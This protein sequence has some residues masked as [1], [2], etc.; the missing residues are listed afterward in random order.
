[1]KILLLNDY[2]TGIAGAELI[3][4]GL[5][6]E[7]RRRGHEAWLLSSSARPTPTPM[8]AD[9]QCLGTT[10]RWRTL[11]QCGNLSAAR[12]LRRVL[13]EFRPDVVHVNLYLTQLSPLILREIRHVPAV[14]YAQWYRAICPVGTKLLPDGRGCRYPVG[15]A[16]L[17]EGCLK[18]IDWPPLIAQMGLDR[19]WGGAF[20]R[21]VAISR[22]VADKLDAWGGPHLR[23]AQ[24]V[25]PGTTVV[26]PRPAGRMATAPTAMAAS[27]LSPEKGIDVLLRAFA[28]IHRDLPDAR[29]VIAGD[30]PQRAALEALSGNLGLGS[31]VEWTGHLPHEQTIERVREAWVVCVPSRWDEPFGLIAA[32]TQMNGVAVVASSCGGL[33]EIIRDGQTGLLVPPGDATLLAERLAR[34]LRNR[35]EAAA[36]GAAGHAAAAIRFGL[37]GF[38]SRFEEVYDSIVR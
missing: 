30:G 5:R 11:L 26:P 4:I 10:S 22:A 3:T 9:E 13:R 15:T 12:T 17:R 19:L 25:H 37:D 2:G 32:E 31:A 1:M 18:P 34:L 29:L 20:D 14:Y 21:V 16:C 23:G 38:A 7:L 28:M 36:L 33:L 24:V 35:D 8:L 27:R 6:D